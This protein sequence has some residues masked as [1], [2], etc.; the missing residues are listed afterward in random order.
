MDIF[1]SL[2]L[3][4]I[5]KAAGITF[6]TILV[7]LALA[8]PRTREALAGLGVR[9]LDAAVAFAERWLSEET[10]DRRERAQ[11]RRAVDSVRAHQNRKMSRER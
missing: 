7:V 11:Y 3:G 1:D 9:L 6:G 10:L 2:S 5:L 4:V 8:Y